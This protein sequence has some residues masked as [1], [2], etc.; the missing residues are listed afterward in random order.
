MILILAH[1]L[2]FVPYIYQIEAFYSKDDVFTFK[3]TKTLATII[4]NEKCMRV[5]KAT[6]YNFEL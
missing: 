3:V 1:T 5:L 4:F 2:Y 6:D